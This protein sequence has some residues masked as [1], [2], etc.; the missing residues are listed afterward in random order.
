MECVFYF[1]FFSIPNISKKKMDN[2][3]S[4]KVYKITGGNKIYIGSTSTT[5]KRRFSIHKAIYRQWLN[6][7]TK[8]TCSMFELFKNYGLL[9]CNIELLEELKDCTKE[10]LLKKEAEYIKNNTDIAINKNIPCRTPKEFYNDNRDVILN[11]QRI[12]D[13]ANKDKKRLYYLKHKDDISNK[14]KIYY[15]NKKNTL[16]QKIEN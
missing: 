10:K 1:F 9:G 16:T 6:D 13:R 15:Q 8:N 12:R 2:I 14:R 5:L 11:K 3:K 7:K 4:G